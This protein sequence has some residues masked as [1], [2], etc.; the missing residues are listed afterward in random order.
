MKHIIASLLLALT[1][2]PVAYPK[3]GV[4][5]TYRGQLAR[6]QFMVQTGYPN[7][8]K[9]WVVDHIFPLCKGGKDEPANMQWQTAAEAKKKD[10]TECD[11][12]L[13]PKPIKP[14]KK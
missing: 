5:T 10:R 4:P 12:K 1:L 13:D 2:A 8:R 3:C 9:G 6:H 11:C 14:A 7:G